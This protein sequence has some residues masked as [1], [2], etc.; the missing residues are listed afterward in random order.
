MNISNIGNADKQAAGAW[1]EFASGVSFLIAAI[2]NRNFVKKFA[3][4]AEKARR[5]KRGEPTA[6]ENVLIYWT[7]MAGTVLLD[8]KGLTDGPDDQP[9]PFSEENAVKFLTADLL[10]VEEIRSFIIATAKDADGFAVEEK[11]ADVAAIKSV[12][13]VGA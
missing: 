4:L 2:S 12:A 7:A 8:W 13:P 11:A 9:Y 6:E 10:L 3:K 1:F 5:K